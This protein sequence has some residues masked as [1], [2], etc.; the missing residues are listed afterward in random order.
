MEGSGDGRNL[1]FV[2]G[3]RQVIDRR[4]ASIPEPVVRP[5]TAIVASSSNRSV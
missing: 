2:A 4:A 5:L 1:L 3:R